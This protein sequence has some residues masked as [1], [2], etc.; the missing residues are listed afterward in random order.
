MTQA[1]KCPELVARLKSDFGALWGCRERGDSVELVTPFCTSSQKFVSVFISLREKAFI[2]SDGGW[3]GNET[4]FYGRGAEPEEEQ[5]CD[6]VKHFSEVFRVRIG[7]NTKNETVY[8]KTTDRLDLLSGAVFDIA[9]FV[10]TV[11]NAGALESDEATANRTRFRRE[12]RAFVSAEFGPDKARFN[13]KVPG[14]NEVRFNAVVY[15]RPNTICLISYVTGSTPFYFSREFSNAIVGFELAN[16]KSS[17]QHLIKSR[18]ALLNDEADG[19]VAERNGQL[20][21]L[22]GRHHGKAVT[23]TNRSELLDTIRSWSGN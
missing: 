7:T 2:V 21:D 13:E 18:I 14:L 23:W 15:P 17:A 20:L 6:C 10:V 3:L 22:L 1:L 19:Y 4:D 11:A 9:N 8:Y 5:Y 12:A 16:T